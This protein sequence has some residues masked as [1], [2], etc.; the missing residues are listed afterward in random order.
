MAR[1]KYTSQDQFERQQHELQ[2][3]EGVNPNPKNSEGMT[4]EGESHGELVI[5][6]DSEATTNAT[7]LVAV[8]Q[9]LPQPL[10]LIPHLRILGL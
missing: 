6:M 4:H 3:S 8:V 2:M 5:V 10:F 1:V 7:T 9:G